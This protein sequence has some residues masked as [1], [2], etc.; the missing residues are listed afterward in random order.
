[1]AFRLL[2]RTKPP[3]NHNYNIILGLLYILNNKV[4]ALIF[5]NHQSLMYGLLTINNGGGLDVNHTKLETFIIRF[6]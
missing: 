3:T 5:L 1:M 2:I 4:A 6:I